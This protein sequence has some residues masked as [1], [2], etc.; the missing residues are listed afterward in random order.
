MA[1]QEGLLTH[2]YMPELLCPFVA[3]PTLECKGTEFHGTHLN[4]HYKFT[5]KNPQPQPVRLPQAA[6]P[7]TDWLFLHF[8]LTFLCCVCI[9]FG[10]Q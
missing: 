1:S 7:G 2:G 3:Y 4:L 5:V 9:C 6:R 10:H 8:M